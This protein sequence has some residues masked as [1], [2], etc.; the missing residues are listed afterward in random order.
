MSFIERLKQRTQQRFAD[1]ERRVQERRQQQAPTPTPPAPPAPPAPQRPVGIQQLLKA[2]QPTIE[3]MRPITEPLAEIA[4]PI[5]EPIKTPSR[6]RIR[7]KEEQREAQADNWFAR[8][9]MPKRVERTGNILQDTLA[10]VQR[11]LE[12]PAARAVMEPFVAISKGAGGVV[13]GDIIPRRGETPREFYKRQP[14]LG[15]VVSRELDKTGIPV[16]PIVGGFLAEALLPPY[17]VGGAGRF[18]DDIIKAT[19]LNAKENIIKKGIK[20]ITNDEA[21]TLARTLTPIKNKR[22]VQQRLD[23][24]VRAKQQTGATSTKAITPPTLVKTIRDRAREGVTPPVPISSQ[25]IK[26]SAREV[27]KRMARVSPEQPLATALNKNQYLRTKGRVARFMSFFKEKLDNDWNRVREIANDPNLPVSE[28]RLTP[29]ERKKLYTGRLGTRIEQAENKGASVL[30]DIIN[31]AKT[32]GVADDVLRKD[33]HEYLIAK[34]A[35]ERN[36]ALGNPRAAGISNEEAAAIIQRIEASPVAGEVKRIA[37][38]IRAI[39]DE[40]LDILYQGGRSEGIINTELY[41][42][43]KKRYQNHIPLHRILPEKEGQDIAQVLSGRGFDVRGTGII[44]AKG[45]ELPVSDVIE[46]TFA[47]L[48]EA[49]QRVEKNIVDNET[50]R[51]AR[52][53]NEVYPGKNLFEEIRPKAIG[54]TFDG[55]GVITEQ[56]KDA[57]VLSMREAGEQV[58]LRINDPKLAVVFRGINREVLPSYIRFSHSFVRFTGALLTRYNL[59]FALSN[60]IRDLQEVIIY[61]FSQKGAGFGVARKAVSKDAQSF[62]DIMSWMGG[63]DT[64]GAQLYQQMR[65][66]G[67]TTGGLALSTKEQL[68]KTFDGIENEIKAGS[69]KKGARR[70]VEGIDKWNQLFEDSTRLSAYKAMLENGATREKAAIAA[71]DATI[72]FNEYGTAGPVINALYMFASASMKGSFKMIRAMRNPRVAA[73]TTLTVG[74]AVFATSNWNDRIDPEWRK[75]VTRW[76]RANNLNIVLPHSTEERLFYISIPVSWGLKPIKVAMDYAY[77]LATGGTEDL[78]GA[79]EGIIT[80]AVTG[81]NP[82]GEQSLMGAITPTLLDVPSQIARN[83]AWFG[84]RIRPEPRAHEAQADLYFRSLDD[85]PLGRGLITATDRVHEAT[86]GRIDISPADINYAI[87]QYIGGAGRFASQIM[88][89]IAAV[90]IGEVPPVREMPFV[91]RFL[92]ARDIEETGA[93]DGRTQNIRRELE[94]QDRAEKKQQREVRR[95]YE[96]IEGLPTEKEKAALWDEYV[97]KNIITKEISDKLLPLLNRQTEDIL[98]LDERLIKE[99]GVRNGERARHIYNYMMSLPTQE[100]RAALWDEYVRKK[101]ITKEVSDQL[102]LLLN[103]Q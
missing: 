45:S 22:I 59:P 87:N 92:R 14:Q 20:G 95:I 64:P 96:K 29:A 43:L 25:M 76:D 93:G 74:G 77:D 97:Q 37:Q 84:G 54:R 5:V 98:T 34:H 24:F 90:G 81:Y 83:E 102:M 42:L 9:L 55:K 17:G 1:A 33:I 60:K 8:M 48:M 38:G 70:L 72:D 23:D 61:L 36:L 53:F 73:A 91:S 35:P 78:A 89:T 56:I 71:K 85:T 2:V 86:D 82:L 79:F 94:L 26:E 58:Y 19:T 49:V 10:N 7:T 39:D 88:N 57:T 50:L 13:T 40:V 44:R 16:L 68:V 66:D 46:N 15:E 47:N 30:I 11:G 31:T 32:T 62:G 101:I 75:K 12:T 28:G 3:A 51:F 52:Q 67:G 69:I 80:A 18:A 103:P 21:T 100:E 99:F 27:A 41:N 63:K 6:I 65:M 4:R